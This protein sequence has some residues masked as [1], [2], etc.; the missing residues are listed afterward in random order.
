MIASGIADQNPMVLC[1]LKSRAFP[2]SP[3][4]N[5]VMPRRDDHFHDRGHQRNRPLT[6]MKRNARFDA[7][8]TARP[9]G[10]L[11]P[12]AATSGA[13]RQRP[14]RTRHSLPIPFAESR[15]GVRIDK[16]LAAGANR[17]R[18]GRGRIGSHH[19]RRCREIGPCLGDLRD[20]RIGRQPLCRGLDDVSTGV[21]PC[22]DLALISQKGACH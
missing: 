22:R 5:Q 19:H 15:A 3:L 13:T 9:S 14:G 10:R 16:E 20:E 11:A 6:T 7:P 2:C 21:R 17:Q 1:Q 12:D 18:C 8:V 4:L